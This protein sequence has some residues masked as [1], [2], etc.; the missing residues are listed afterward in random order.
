MV[1]VLVALVV[2][3]VGMLGIASLYVITLQAKITSQSRMQAVNLAMDIAERIRANRTAGA[4]YNTG[5]VA[6]ADNGCADTD[7]V[8]TTAADDCNAADIAQNDLF[9]WDAQ[10]T[11]VLP[12]SPSGSVAVDTST[13]PTTYSIVLNW[14]EP[15]G[16]AL[17]YTMQVQI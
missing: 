13:S 12:G 11:S 3:G 5:S 17:S 1:E 6:G 8:T 16:G 15:S 4:G 2:M 7:V 10:I 9:L 14:T